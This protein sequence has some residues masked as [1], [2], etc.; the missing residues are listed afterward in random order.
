MGYKSPHIYTINIQPNTTNPADSKTYYFGS[1]SYAW[2]DGTPGVSRIYICKP[3]ILRC[4][5]LYVYCTVIASAEDVAVSIR[6]NDT[7]DYSIDAAV[8][9][10]A[11]STLVSNKTM[12]IPLA[13][14]DYIEIKVV[15]P[16]WVTNPT[17]V[18]V[19]GHILIE[20]E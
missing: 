2:V 13:A 18:F 16:A 10:N 3:G 7:T 1:T 12:N 20:C 6:K 5:T 19:G 14:D 8:H 9:L 15:T 17:G 11:A 4:A